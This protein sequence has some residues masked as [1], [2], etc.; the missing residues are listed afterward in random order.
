MVAP[1]A[2]LRERR[3]G[4]D[5]PADQ[6]QVERRDHHCAHDAP[7]GLATTRQGGGH[8]QR[9]TERDPKMNGR[10]D[11]K[12]HRRAPL[13]RQHHDADGAAPFQHVLASQQR[14]HRRGDRRTH[15]P[16]QASSQGV[17]GNSPVKTAAHASI[18][19]RAGRRRAGRVLATL[20]VVRE[21][22]LEHVAPAGADQ[23]DR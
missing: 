13:R 5:P 21:L 19:A 1:L 15:R 7:G 11:R 17:T 4:R 6:R 2:A 10:G 23:P 16:S 3:D 9:P 20:L 12:Q 18:V 8:H 14:P 22:S